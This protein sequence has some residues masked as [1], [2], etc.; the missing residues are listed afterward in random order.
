MRVGP[1]Y[2]V[3]AVTWAKTEWEAVSTVSGSTDQLC[4][5]INNM[6]NATGTL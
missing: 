4:L 6:N 3:I 2:P 5:A 1:R